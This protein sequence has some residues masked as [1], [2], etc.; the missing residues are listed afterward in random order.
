MEATV[1]AKGDKAAYMGQSSGML[2][3]VACSVVLAFWAYLDPI[4]DGKVFM[5]PS[6]SVGIVTTYTC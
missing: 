6:D 4:N 1:H 5:E 2:S 3:E